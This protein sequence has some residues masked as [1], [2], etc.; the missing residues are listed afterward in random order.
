MA[1]LYLHRAKATLFVAYNATQLFGKRIC[2][3]CFVYVVAA[4]FEVR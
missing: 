4:L 1:E 3:R 2:S